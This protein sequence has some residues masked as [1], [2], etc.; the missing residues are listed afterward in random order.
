MA[1]RRHGWAPPV[2][3]RRILLLG[4]ALPLLLAGCTTI[5]PQPAGSLSSYRRLEPSDGLLTKSQLS[6]DKDAVLAANSVRI[7][8]TAFAPATSEAK[9]SDAQLRL[10]GNEIDRSL[11][12]GLS[13]RF[14][15]ASAM[16]PAELT[17]H[18]SVTRIVPTDEIAATASSVT[19]LGMTAVKAAGVVTAPIPTL[20]FPIGL[21]GLAVEAE[22]VDQDGAQKAA[23]MWGRGADSLT[24]RARA[25]KAGDAYE[26]A[27]A[28]GADFSQLVVSGESPFKK[29]PPTLP[30]P[31][32]IKST[33]GGAHKEAACEAFGRAPG[34]PGFVGGAIGLPPEWTDEGAP[35]EATTAN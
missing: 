16:E 5:A 20:R 18:A 25:S 32:E 6:V 34:V 26:L 10:I 2:S 11:C 1:Y 35:V 17:V 33:F 3:A 30:S 19:G 29:K 21:G 14:R 8:P 27:S 4:F 22:A 28:F 7:V 13:R 23:M 31:D 15:I 12:I 24:T 9:L